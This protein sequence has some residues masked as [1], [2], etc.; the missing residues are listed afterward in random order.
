METNST[1]SVWSIIFGCLLVVIG[2]GYCV[3]RY[4]SNSR[5]SCEN[6]SDKSNTIEP[7]SSELKYILKYFTGSM[8][9]L[10]EI[11]MN[12]DLSMAKVTFENIQQIIKVKG[13]DKLKEWYYCFEKDRN[14]WD[15]IL[16]KNKAVEIMNIF[17]ECGLCSCEDKDLIWD[18]ESS[19]KYNKLSPIQ[20]GQ[21]CIIVAPYWVYN[22][23]VFE[24]GLVRPK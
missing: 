3:F 11:S 19:K 9:A 23:E 5:K 7:I 15:I 16:Y 20:L 24:K 1:I 8:N 12:P 6:E 22:G 10:R 2:V 21:E 13:T 17:I 4:L 14:S 18:N